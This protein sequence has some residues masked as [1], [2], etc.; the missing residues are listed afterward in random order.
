MNEHVFSLGKYPIEINL[1]GY[2]AFSIFL[3]T[4]CRYSSPLF[5][6]MRH[7]EDLLLSSIYLSDM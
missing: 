1:L 5:L 4:E 7:V 2:E 3:L 6:A